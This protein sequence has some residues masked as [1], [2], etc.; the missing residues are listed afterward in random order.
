[1]AGLHVT[2]VWD[3]V[4]WRNELMLR[5]SHEMLGIL[6]KPLDLTLDISGC[7]SKRRGTSVSGL[8]FEPRVEGLEALAHGD[9]CRAVDLLALANETNEDVLGTFWFGIALLNSGQRTMAIEVLREIDA[10]SYFVN[11]AKSAYAEQHYEEAQDLIDLGLKIGPRTADWL[12]WRGRIQLARDDFEAAYQ[13]YLETLAL[14][15]HMSSALADIGFIELEYLRDSRSAEK[16]LHE[17]LDLNAKDPQIHLY[18]GMLAETAADWVQA[19][20][21][22]EQAISYAEGS[23]YAYIRLAQ[24]VW[25]QGN[26]SQAEQYFRTAVRMYPMH[27]N[28]NWQLGHYIMQTK[29]ETEEAIRYFRVATSLAPN[30]PT[31]WISL[32]DGLREINSCGEAADAF[33]QALEIEPSNA[34]AQMQLDEVIQQCVVLP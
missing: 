31:Y 11:R 34:Y 2:K 28:A 6:G 29:G 21:E 32:G 22:Y 9:A 1:M 18:L 10:G 12:Y 14:A 3:S 19:V 17:A 27:A 20:D 13:S 25:R 15:P 24:L 16:H 7:A 33:R 30:D 26:Y 5:L 8:D 23:V 4:Y